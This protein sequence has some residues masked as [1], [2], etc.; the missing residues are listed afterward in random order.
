[1]FGE[2]AGWQSRWAVAIGSRS[3]QLQWAVA[4]GRW[5]VGLKVGEL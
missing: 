4:V 2:F 1:M 3:G 5:V